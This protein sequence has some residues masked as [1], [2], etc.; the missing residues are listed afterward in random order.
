MNF[1]LLLRYIG[2]ATAWG[3]LGTWLIIFAMA[4]IYSN[5]RVV[6]VTIRA[7]VFYEF[8]F[9]FILIAVGFIGISYD[10]YRL[11]LEKTREDRK[12]DSGIQGNI[13]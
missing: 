8:W 13:L 10:I 6:R 9:E 1:K 12:E 2:R 11:S 7:N 5:E 4:F 3:C